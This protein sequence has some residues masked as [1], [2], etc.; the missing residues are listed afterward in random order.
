MFEFHKK[1]GGGARS[2]FPIILQMQAEHQYMFRIIM[3]FMKASFERDR[4]SLMSVMNKVLFR[5]QM[6]INI[7]NAIK[8]VRVG[9]DTLRDV[10]QR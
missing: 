5:L 1:G 8:K 2:L 9:F 4:T 6:R 10:F 7:H 3:I